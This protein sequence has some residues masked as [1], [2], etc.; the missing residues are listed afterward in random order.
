VICSSCGYGI[1][2]KPYPIE[3]GK[4]YVCD[5]CWNN[6]NL[7][8]PEKL[9]SDDRLKLLSE[10]ANESRNQLGSIHVGVI[11]LCQKDIEM[12]VG[13]MK[14]KD[15]LQLYEIDRFKEEELKGYQR[16]Q[17][18][19]R[20]AEL[21]EYLVKCP[22][23][24]MPS[25]FISLREGRFISEN[26]DFGV[27]EIPRNRSSIWIID[28]QHR[29][30]GFEKVYN[31]FT[32]AQN[33][34]DIDPDIFRI[35]MNYELPVVFIDTRKAT[36]RAGNINNAEKQGITPEDLERAIF[37]IVNKTQKGI[38][39]SLKDAL[40]YRIKIGGIEGIP[41][42]RKESWR[43]HAAY[44]GISLNREKDSPLND[45]I[46][47]S[48]KK[49][50]G[51]PIQLNSFISSLQPLLTDKDFSKLSDD[52]RLKFVKV[53]WSV[54]RKM[55]PEAFDANSWREYMVMKAIG[56]YCLNWLA[57]DIFKICI[58]QRYPYDEE[59]ILYV[60]LEPLR[61][62]DWKR[63]TSPLCTLAGMK[64]ARKGHNILFETLNYS[65][66]ELEAPAK[67]QT[68]VESKCF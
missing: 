45:K 32:F 24:V 20:T 47:I 60:L 44:I 8:F 19:E 18:E 16:E 25:L 5:R 64:G 61:F 43:I 14:S 65:V 41:I 31:R 40:L 68:S 66:Q 10:I 6:P 46:N 3:N 26:G 33:P 15:I 62:F 42:L 48:G 9:Y 11:K 29:I 12:Y 17:Y 27:L 50:T 22:V 36:E 52:E 13:K 37:F 59:K 54:L 38:S 51:R 34:S 35:L 56:V 63:Q 1:R 57:H 23:A 39:P 4:K 49:E 28:G 21:L 53:F 58:Q 67:P 30:G 55:F 7:F 2:G